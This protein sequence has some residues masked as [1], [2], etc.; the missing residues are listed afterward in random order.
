MNVTEAQRSNP[1]Q[2]LTPSSWVV[3]FAPLIKPG[4]QVL[5]L[6]SGYGRHARHLAALGHAVLAVDRDAAALA[7]LGGIAGIASIETQAVDLEQGTWPFAAQRFDAIIVTHYLHRPLFADLLA[8]LQPD[9]VLI[10]ETFAAGNAAFGKPARPEFLLQPDELLQWLGSTLRV[11]AFEQGQVTS[12]FPAVIQRI[13]A[14]GLE[15]PWPTPLPVSP[16]A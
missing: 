15:R 14:I 11:A 8:A 16:V 9:G 13:C 2:A 6:A 3:R 4:G 7:T 12:P 1:H 5:D 10:Y